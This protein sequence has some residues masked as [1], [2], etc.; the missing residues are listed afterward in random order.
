ML[1]EQGPVSR[2]LFRTSGRNDRILQKRP[3]AR[4]GQFN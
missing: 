3:R 1:E 2:S 4:R